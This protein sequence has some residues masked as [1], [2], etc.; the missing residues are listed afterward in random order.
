MMT[1]DASPIGGAPVGVRLFAATWAAQGRGNSI[2]VVNGF[3]AVSNRVSYHADTAEGA[4]SG[5]WRK[6]R[7]AVWKPPCTQ[8]GALVGA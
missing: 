5:L 1:L 6:V 3:I 8:H 4:M 7:S 2:N